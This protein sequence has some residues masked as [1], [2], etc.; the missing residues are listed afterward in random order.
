MQINRDPRIC[1]QDRTRPER[2]EYEE[3]EKTPALHGDAAVYQ[4]KFDAETHKVGQ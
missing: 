4:E 2:R 1:L 3:T